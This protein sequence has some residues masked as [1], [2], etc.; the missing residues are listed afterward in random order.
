TMEQYPTGRASRPQGSKVNECRKTPP[1]PT[2]PKVGISPARPH[3]EAGPRIDPPVS[4]P[5]AIG[6]SP[7]ATAAP[8]PLEEPPVKCARSHGL[9]AG[10]HGRSKDGPPCA[11]S[12]VASLPMRIAPA[13]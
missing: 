4:D 5:S 9:R 12:W 13:S 7:A 8:E 10:G 2:R 1:R 11:N 6:T 3:N